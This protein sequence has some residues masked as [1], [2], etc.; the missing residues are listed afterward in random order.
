MEIISDENLSWLMLLF[1]GDKLFLECSCGL[2]VNFH[3]YF[4][5]EDGH[6][7]GMLHAV[8]EVALKKL[9]QHIQGPPYFKEISSLPLLLV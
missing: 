2:P 9:A 3:I 6:S 1:L 4:W 8:S 5:G 7:E